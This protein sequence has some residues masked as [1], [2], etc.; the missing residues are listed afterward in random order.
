MGN[1]WINVKFEFVQVHGQWEVWM[2]HNGFYI[3]KNEDR[4]QDKVSIM[5]KITFSSFYPGV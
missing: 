1:N 5:P 3:L 2:D 4:V